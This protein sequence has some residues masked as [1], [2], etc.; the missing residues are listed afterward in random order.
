MHDLSY[1]ELLSQELLEE[2]QWVMNDCHFCHTF[3]LFCF[4]NIRVDHRTIIS[5][6]ET[7]V[8]QMR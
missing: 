2:K 3:I 1:P 4:S 6:P 5:F 8:I 7:E